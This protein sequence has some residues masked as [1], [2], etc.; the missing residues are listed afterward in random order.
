[1][2]T[3]PTQSFLLEIAEKSDQE[4]QDGGITFEYKY[5]HRLAHTVFDHNFLKTTADIREFNDKE[6]QQIECFFTTSLSLK[7]KDTELKSKEFIQLLKQ[8][9]SDYY[10]Q[11]SS[12]NSDGYSIDIVIHFIKDNDFHELNLFWSM[13]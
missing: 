4:F 10:R 5:A 1:M 7:Q 6:V 13:D 9:F 11:I 8:D 12:F 2:L 3:K